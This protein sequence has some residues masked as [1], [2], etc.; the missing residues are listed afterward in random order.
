MPPIYY[1]Y[2]PINEYSEK[3][4][5]KQK[6]FFSFGY[7]YIDP[8]D[9][10][11]KID[12]S[13]NIEDILNVLESTSLPPDIKDSIRNKILNNEITPEK[14]LFTAYEVAKKTIMSSC[15]S[16]DSLNVL[17][18]SHY[19]DSHKG[20]CLGFANI[21]N[22]EY[23]ALKFDLGNVPGDP[24][25]LENGVFPITKVNYDTNE[26]IRWK[27]FQ[28]DISVF[29]DAHTN[30]AKYWEYEKEHR[31]ILAFKEYGTKI[32]CFDRRFLKE[33]YLGTRIEKADKL[34]YIEI[35]KDEYLKKGLP[36]RVFQT[37]LSESRFELEM[38]EIKIGAF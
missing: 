19:A 16:S 15:F 28:N 12:T 35:I 22:E 33:V 17:M 4:L 32:L 21:R 25:T 29:M 1:K 6:I 10:K 14:L 37:L 23:P 38:E 3:L 26:I 36:V 5:R 11:V 34:K 30:K 18:W 9:S 13:G 31:I 24:P 2:R 8:F 7:E 20:I 27:P